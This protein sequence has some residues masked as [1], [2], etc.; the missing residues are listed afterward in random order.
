METEIHKFS[1][2]GQSGIY[3]EFFYI[4]NNFSIYKKQSCILREFD[5]VA[6]S[7]QVSKE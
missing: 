5:V 4:I 2:D 1:P 6:I 7:K 3:F